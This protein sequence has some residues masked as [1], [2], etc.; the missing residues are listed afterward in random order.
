MCRLS[1]KKYTTFLANTLSLLRQSIMVI[2]CIYIGV[3][4]N[5][6]IIKFADDTMQFEIQN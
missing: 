1:L 4:Y 2:I 3:N 5:D 6:N